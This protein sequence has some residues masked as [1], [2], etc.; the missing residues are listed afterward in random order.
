MTLTDTQLASLT[1]LFTDKQLLTRRVELL[2]YDGDASLNKGMP[3]GV[4]FVHTA[5]EVSQVVRWANTHRVPLVARGAG[6]GLSGGAVAE[7]GGVIVEFSRMKRIVELDE[8]GRRVV[9]EPGVV[10]LVLDEFVRAKGL[11]FPPDPASGRTATIGGNLAENAGGPHC[12]K[13]GVTTNYFTGMQV[14][15]ADGRVIRLGGGALDYPEYDLMG[16]L[17]GGE[18]TLGIITQARARLLRRI[19]ATQTLL[20]SFDSVEQ[21]GNAVSAVIARG[22]VPATLEMMDQ[23]MV[24]IVEEF[25][26]AG[27]P[28][29]AGAVLIVEVDGYPESVTSQMEHVAAIMRENDARDLRRA[30]TA[31]ERE[32]IW[33]GRKSAIGAM[34][35][36]APAYYLLD[37]TVPRSKLAATLAGVNQLC[38]ASGLRVGYVFHAGDGNLHPLVLI[39]DPQDPALMERIHATGRK[40]MQLC[41]AMGGSITGE[42]GVGIEKREFMPL[43]YTPDELAAMWDVK[44]IF[45]PL[46]ILNP[47]KIFPTATP[48]SPQSPLLSGEGVADEI[49]PRNAAEAA[50]AIRAW[51]AQGKKIFI[52][53]DET[54]P[55][56]PLRSRAGAAGE[57]ATLLTRNLRGITTRA[58]EDL[59]VTV[60][61]GTP[62]AELQAELA[63][64]Q[65]W[66]PLVSPFQD[67]TIGGII[68]TNFNAP[69]RMKY[70][71][72]RDLLLAA[73]V[74]LPDGRAIGAGRPVV[75]NVAGYDLPKLFVGSYGTLGL[76]VDATLKLAPLPRARAS[77]IAPVDDLKRGMELGAELSRVCL[78]ASGLLVWRGGNIPGSTAPYALIYTAEGIEED[79][80]AELAQAR[81]V[82]QNEGVSHLAQLDAP[83][84]ND[85][86]ADFWRAPSDAPVLRAGVAPK[87]LPA[88]VGG[89]ALGDA[90][91]IADIPNGMLYTRGAPLE[92]VRPAALTLGGYAIVLNGQ[93]GD[94]WGYRPEGLDLMRALKARWDPRGLFNPGMFVV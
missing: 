35:R 40:I 85:V 56:A 42:H 41:V 63:R 28:L 25:A 92:R 87:D 65:M 38:Q 33:Y 39:A 73:R 57:G 20:A 45:D 75:K 3:A 59:Y 2:T 15:L 47:G 23:Q 60:N 86:W 90:S 69:L 66:V 11:Y 91:L 4:V 71:G 32:R 14:V 76:I 1:Q 46:K 43:M 27:L 58:L 16:V 93:T 17:I 82:L 21:A 31:D 7:R 74:V 84:A 5:D 6:T 12:F 55:R 51:N 70:G 67:A 18:G 54:A 79:V 72:I 53:R 29:D 24:R 8:A 77:I 49:A 61:A 13:Y 48:T 68:A 34:A 62:L 44:E 88:F 80:N 26:H 10:N 9:V 83:S 89:L 36:L 19:P 81:A 52:A 94:A 50:R 64:D 78:V 30:H 22:V 37:G